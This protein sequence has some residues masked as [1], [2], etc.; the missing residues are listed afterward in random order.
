MDDSPAIACIVEGEGDEKAVPILIRRVGERLD[1]PMYP[2][3]SVVLRWPRSSLVKTGVLEAA[4]ETAVRRSGGPCAV[5]VLIDADDDCPATLGP[6]LLARA[7]Q[8]RRDLPVGVVLAKYEYEAW[9]LAAAASLAGHRQLSA[10]LQ[11]PPNPEAIRGAKGWL[12]ARMP[13]DRRYSETADQPALTARFDM[14]LAR[15]N[16]DSFDKC[17]REIA[18][19]LTDLARPVEPGTHPMPPIP[20]V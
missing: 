9:L 13:Q 2:H 7:Q 20:R 5:L 18:R 6:Q 15:A 8:T 19:L 4:V 1:P 10:D 14:D 16:A 11:S 12:E 3:V 17:Y